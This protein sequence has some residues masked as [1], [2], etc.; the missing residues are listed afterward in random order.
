MLS[1]KPDFL[2]KLRTVAE[3]TA[4]QFVPS[5]LFPGIKPHF[6]ISAYEVL[7]IL[8]Y[9]E[10]LEDTLVSVLTE[11]LDLSKLLKKTQ[12]DLK[13]TQYLSVIWVKILNSFVPPDKKQDVFKA[14]AAGIT[15]G[16]KQANID[17]FDAN[18]EQLE[19]QIN[20]E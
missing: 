17:E 7:E 6:T 19:Q 10:T 2:H 12:N 1:N 11:K 15:E 16:M 3:E 9:I 20:P 8:S 5:E 18:L 14:C 4:E 13:Q